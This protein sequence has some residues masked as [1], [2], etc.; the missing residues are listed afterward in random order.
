M[1]VSSIPETQKSRTVWDY[2]PFVRKSKRAVE[3][4]FQFLF[5]PEG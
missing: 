4:Y 1:G 5:E 3:N 2:R